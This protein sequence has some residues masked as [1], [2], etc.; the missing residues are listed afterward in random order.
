[1]VNLRLAEVPAEARSDLCTAYAKDI[2][3]TCGV[4]ESS[5]VDLEGKKAA[6]S[7]S[8]DSSISA[9]VLGIS[10]SSANELAARLY[11]PSFRGLLVNSTLVSTGTHADAGT[12]EISVGAVDLQPE[13]FVPQVPTTTHTSTMSTTATST[14]SATSNGMSTS[15]GSPSHHEGMGGADEQKKQTGPAWWWF[16][17]GAAAVGGA[18]AA[19]CAV[20]VQRKRQ[21][22]AN[23][24][25]SRV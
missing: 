8:E 12:R 9:F 22:G 6:V 14:S 13:Q 18:A 4:D 23:P 20:A 5:V 16:V 15:V 3:S 7:I 10:G 25:G 19:A 1:M 17:A 2:A 11:S 24:A 21:T